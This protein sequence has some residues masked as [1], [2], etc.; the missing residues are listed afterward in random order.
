MKKKINI[1]AEVEKTLNCLDNY[2]KVKADPFFYTRL[3]IKLEKKQETNV[4]N[5]IFNSPL[6]RTAIVALIII[7]NVLSV[8]YVIH[9]N[10]ET[11][12]TDFTSLFTEEYMLDQSTE[13]YLVLNNE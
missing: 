8:N 11:M 9:E 6:L 12:D 4:L 1:Q 7:I 13:S 2:K 3:S 5:L 10:K